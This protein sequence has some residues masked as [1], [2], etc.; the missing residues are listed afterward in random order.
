MTEAVSE[1][2]R[3]NF[4]FFFF[5]FCR[6]QENILD[7]KKT[8]PKIFVFCTSPTLMYIPTR[9]CNMGSLPP[10]IVY[11]SHEVVPLCLASPRDVKANQ[12]PL[13]Q[14]FT[15]RIP[16]ITQV[17]SHLGPTGVLQEKIAEKK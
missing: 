3:S 17:F 9:P 11:I 13:C 7:K 2:P 10:Y 8:L 14:G 4:F 12:S 15:C 5:F 16:D 1:N 6:T